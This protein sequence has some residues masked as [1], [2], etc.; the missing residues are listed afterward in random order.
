MF[1]VFVDATGAMVGVL[2]FSLIDRR[3]GSF[4]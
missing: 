1:D 2:V 3:A 4:T